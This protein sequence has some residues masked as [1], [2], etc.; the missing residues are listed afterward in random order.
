M[1][2]AVR[3]AHAHVPYYRDAMRRS[4]LAPEDV[5]GASDL[6]RLPVIEREQL[7]ADPEYFVAQGVSRRGW[8]DAGEPVGARAGP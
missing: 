6:A 4:G 2:A 3:Y 7:Q 8:V 5:A 1:R